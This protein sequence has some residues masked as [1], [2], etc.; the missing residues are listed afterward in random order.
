MILLHAAA[1]IAFPFAVIRPVD[2]LAPRAVLAGL[3]GGVQEANPR[4]PGCS[5]WQ[6]CRQLA[7][8]AAARQ[9]FELFHDLAWRAVQTGPKNDPAL[10]Y[11]LARAQSLSGRPGDALV[12]LQRLAAMGVETDAAASD[13]FRRVRALPGWTALSAGAPG[14]PSANSTVTSTGADRGGGAPVMPAP[15]RAPSTEASGMTPAP[16]VRDAG[17]ANRERTSP[18]GG[19]ALSKAGAAT[20]TVRFTTPQFTPAGL[21]Y[22]AVSR[23][24]IVGDRHAR[25]LAVVDEFSRHVA[26]LASAQTSGFGEIAALEID[27]HQGNLWVVSADVQET[28]LHKLQLVSGR[29]LGSYAVPGNLA[30][31]RFVDVAATAQSTVL[32]LDSAG[33]RLFQLRPKATSLELAAVLPDTAP[34]SVAP[35]SDTVAYIAHAG[36]V[37]RVDL[38]SRVNVEVR[39][40]AGI[41]LTGITRLRWHQGSLIA[42]Q[43]IAGGAARAVKFA[44]DRAGRTVT[45]A[46]LLDASLPAIEPAAAAISG[47]A[48][49]YLTSGE[50][51]EMIVRRIELR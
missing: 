30:P 32:V 15:G 35:A 34:A 41:D 46:T 3:D 17:P 11:L 39:T 44:L 48:L 2:T 6:A 25:K 20:E 5:D 4:R 50:G 47:D 51:T 38:A 14:P 29:S 1:I 16:V 7:V 36:G 24:F 27:S 12:M 10:M 45:S 49:F 31:A 13:D 28:I 42:V 33:H 19:A 22:D 37:T 43:Q 26:N 8:D 21:A 9:D 23:R 18:A 40:A